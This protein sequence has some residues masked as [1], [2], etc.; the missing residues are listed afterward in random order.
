MKTVALALVS[1]ALAGC[2][3]RHVWSGEIE[4]EGLVVHQGDSFSIR[5]EGLPEHALYVIQL[6]QQVA[7]RLVLKGW[8]HGAYSDG[9]LDV[10]ITMDTLV[11]GD[12]RGRQADCRVT[13]YLSRGGQTWRFE[14]RGD[15][16]GRWREDRVP[17]AISNTARAVVDRLVSARQD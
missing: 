9:N 13:V 17:T 8:E 4:P 6:E 3:S 11:T 16:A 1:L 2:T 7:D 5:G 10:L 15:S 14:A 12:D